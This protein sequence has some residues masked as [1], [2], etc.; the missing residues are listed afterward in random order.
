MLREPISH[1]L[2]L[3]N[4]RWYLDPSDGLIQHN[5]H[6]SVVNHRI[7]TPTLSLAPGGSNLARPTIVKAAAH[8]KI[9]NFFNAASV[10]V[11]LFLEGRLY[12]MF[13]TL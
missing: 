12:A 5:K 7:K 2:C 3:N 9:F 1:V 10:H 8:V 13:L 11:W 4:L 6:C